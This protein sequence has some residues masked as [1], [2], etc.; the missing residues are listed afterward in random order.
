LIKKRIV[1]YEEIPGYRH[2][3][4]GLHIASDIESVTLWM[5]NGETQVAITRKN[6]Q[7]NFEE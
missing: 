2:L 7:E 1:V 4:Q 5:K 3:S 6:D